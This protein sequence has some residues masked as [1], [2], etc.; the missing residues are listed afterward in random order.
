MEPVVVSFTSTPAVAEI[1][2]V[3]DH[4]VLRWTLGKTAITLKVNGVDLAPNTVIMSVEGNFTENT[5]FPIAITDASRSSSSKTRLTFL[6]KAY[7][8]IVSEAPSTSADILNLEFNEYARGSALT[9]TVKAGAE[10]LFCY[11]YPA[12]F[13]APRTIRLGRPA[14]VYG[15]ATME[16]TNSTAFTTETISHTNSSGFTEDYIVVTVEEAFPAPYTLI[17][18]Y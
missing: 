18:L 11:A 8:G 6:N 16:F 3:V 17:T 13:G 5:I 15:P 1:G 9:Y 12:R 4:A 10:G 7:Y 2:S 14:H